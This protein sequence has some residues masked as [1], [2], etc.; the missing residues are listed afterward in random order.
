[1]D[2]I[3]QQTTL[4][5][6]GGKKVPPY[7]DDVFSTFLYE[8]NSSTQTITN[9]IDLTGEGGLVWI[10]SRE[11]NTKNHHLYDTERGAGQRLSSNLTTEERDGS[12]NELMAFTSSG[13]TL[14]IS[15]NVNSTSVGN[16][17][18]WTFRKAPGFFD[19]VTY[20]GNGTAGR[21]ISHQ[22]G[23]VPGMIIVKV[24]SGGT[25]DW[26]VYHR[27]LGDQ[28]IKLNSTNASG[29]TAVWNYT[30]PTSSVFSVGTDGG[31]NGSGRTYVAY[32]FA[33]DDAQYGTD[34]DESIIKC[35]SYTGNSG[36][37]EI[38]LGFEPQFIL[39]KRS[40][41]SSDWVIVDNMR[42]LSESQR[43]ELYANTA[44]SEYTH[45]DAEV[46]VTP[47]GFK[48]LTSHSYYNGSGTYIYM[49]IRRQNKPP[50]AATEVFAIDTRAGTS[51]TPP[52]YK[53]DFP[54]D[55]VW[56]RRSDTGNNWSA[57][58]RLIGEGKEFDL[59]T[60]GSEAANTNTRIEFDRNDGLGTDT[61]AVSTQYAWMFKR[62]PGF[63]DVVTYTADGT[64]N[65]V[66]NHNLSVTPEL[67]FVKI[68]SGSDNWSVYHKDLG[69]TKYLKLNE[70]TAAT[71][72]IGNW[73]NTAPTSTQFTVGGD[74]MVGANTHRYVAYL[75]ATLPG[76]SK[77]GSYSGSSSAQ[78]IDCGFTN[79]ARFVLI[80]RTDS[81][82][83]WMVF[84]TSRG[85]I[86]GS[87]P[88][89]RLDLPNPQSDT[90]FDYIDPYSAGFTI[91]SFGDVNTSGGTYI[92]LA[93][94]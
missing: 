19:V 32:I 24:T 60:T 81:S 2:P 27:S 76:I 14:G 43:V 25:D 38:N 45:P 69:A 83:H 33:H 70:T 57:R 73:Q 42:C 58:T 41:G 89:L 75:F 71:T 66:K 28:R 92:F 7:V 1:M 72:A 61:S 39:I 53:S 26:F 56:E 79:G 67:M 36:S 54:V 77:V 3:T 4:A 20:T 12:S 46:V 80:K 37:Q 15:S 88:G 62:A 11:N 23:S 94:A 49:A 44:D 17:V 48:L 63:F 13:F 34:G 50:E 87:D 8:G 31:V 86:S 84:D 59:N 51:P 5:A 68:R 18:S 9:D 78:N 40:T 82:G 64:N 30:A 85:I 10:K 91:R 22:L 47:T 65:Q 16:Y 6:A 55:W 90:T 74:A 21:T 29:S 93:I 35:G 52:T